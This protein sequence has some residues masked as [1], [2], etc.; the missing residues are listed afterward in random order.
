MAKSPKEL[1]ERMEKMVAAWKNIAR[2][3]KFGEMTWEEFEALAVPVRAKTA[4]IAEL[5]AQRTQA[6][7]DRDDAL[8]LFSQKAQLYING[9]L[10]SPQHGNDSSLYEASGYVRFSERKSGLTKKTSKATPTK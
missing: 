2:N 9:V 6:I 1:I 10:A 5:D 7:N 8:E 4:L 3:E